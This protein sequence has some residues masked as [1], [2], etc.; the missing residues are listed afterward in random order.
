MKR[1]KS[2]WTDLKISLYFKVLLIHMKGQYSKLERTKKVFKDEG[3]LNDPQVLLINSK[4]RI[5]LFFIIS[6]CTK[7]FNFESEITPIGP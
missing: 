3:C 7:K 1:R 2:F 4:L 6:V 5:A